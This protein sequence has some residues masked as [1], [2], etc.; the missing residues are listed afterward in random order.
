MSGKWPGLLDRSEK[1][2]TDAYYAYHAYY[3]N[4]FFMKTSSHFL[5]T[6]IRILYLNNIKFSIQNQSYLYG[7]QKYFLRSKKSGFP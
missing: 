3:A 7:F 1:S 5:E 2:I 4:P 6:R